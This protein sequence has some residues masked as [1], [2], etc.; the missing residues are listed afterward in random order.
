MKQKQ[1]VNILFSILFTFLVV[2][3]VIFFPIYFRSKKTAIEEILIL[4][5]DGIECTDQLQKGSFTLKVAL[6]NR[7]SFTKYS[8]KIEGNLY[9]NYTRNIT[10]TKEIKDSSEILQEGFEVFLK[11]RKG[12]K[13]ETE[14]IQ[15]SSNG[16][17]FIWSDNLWYSKF[18]GSIR[19]KYRFL[20]LW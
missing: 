9:W 8:I 16:S 11:M 10:I 20:I 13:S 4:Q 2:F 7:R 12:V 18:G 15:V 19:I 14:L 3:S 5:I 17:L 1:K 6:I